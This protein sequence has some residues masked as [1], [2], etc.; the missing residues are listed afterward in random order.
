MK[1]GKSEF[2][3][4]MNTRQK[5]TA[6]VFI[7]V[8]L[9]VI[10][11]IWGLFAGG[12]A[13][14]PVPPAQRAPALA[15]IPRPMPQPAPLP[16]QEPLSPREAELLRLQQETQAKYVTALN[17]LQVL[18]ISKEIAEAN[19]AIMAANLA[20]ITAQKSIVDLL[21]PPPPIAPAAYS[22]GLLSPSAPTMPQ[23]PA[24]PST[25]KYT[26]ISV[27]Q[28]QGKWTAVLG[29]QGSLYHV[30]VG[31]VLPAD[32]MIVAAIDRGGV[33]LQK[34]GDRTRVSLVPII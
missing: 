18:K 12:S 29:H 9:I 25:S 13:P 14:T 2:I 22:Q 34:D 27:S 5:I 24:P 15:A 19:Q 21:A 10:W 8:M 7:V 3:S 23:P 31:D 20:T 30:M 11:Q 17:E 1:S 6:I 28:L 33:V 32:G 16:K 26:V 4:S